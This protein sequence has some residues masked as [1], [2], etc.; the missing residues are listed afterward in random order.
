M[1]ALVTVIG[2]DQIGIIGGVCTK[3]AELDVNILD[4][5]QTV[6]QDYFTMMMIVDL[7]TS[8]K[9]METVSSLLKQYGEGRG[10]NIRLQRT[11]IFDAMHTI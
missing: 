9:D 2:H 7:A 6:M 10:L 8:G 3:L 11:D 4:I 1:K 5:S